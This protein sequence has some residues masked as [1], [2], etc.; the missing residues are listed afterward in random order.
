MPTVVRIPYG[1]VFKYYGMHTVAV[2]IRRTLSLNERQVRP[3]FDLHDTQS[4][5]AH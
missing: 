4:F 3:A 2:W 5:M 1:T